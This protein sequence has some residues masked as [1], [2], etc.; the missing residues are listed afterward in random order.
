MATV[1]NATL[2]IAAAVDSKVDVLVQGAINVSA[3]DVN[4]P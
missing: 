4:T 3:S 1:V 2:T